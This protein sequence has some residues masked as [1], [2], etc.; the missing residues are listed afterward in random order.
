MKEA[1]DI[2][3]RSVLTSFFEVVFNIESI[4]NNKIIILIF[5]KRH[6]IVE[7]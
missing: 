7:L 2:F 4:E 1:L 3:K 6:I 5:F